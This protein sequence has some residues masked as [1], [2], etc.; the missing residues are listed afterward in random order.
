MKK[1]VATCFFVLIAYLLSAQYQNEIYNGGFEQDGFGNLLNSSNCLNPTID[2]CTGTASGFCPVADNAGTIF[3]SCGNDFAKQEEYWSHIY[4]WTCPWRR[5]FCNFGDNGVGS[6]NVVCR[7]DSRSGLKLEWG[8]K[9]EFTCA[10]LRSQMVS[11]NIYYV[12]LYNNATNSHI[13]RGMRF[14]TSRPRQCNENDIKDDGPVHVRALSTDGTWKKTTKYYQA[15]NNYS[16]IALNAFNGANEGAGLFDD[17]RIFNLGTDYCAD[18]DWHFQNT[19]LYSNIFQAANEI[20]AGNE[21]M[22][23]HYAYPGPVTIKANNNVIF[24]AGT[25]VVMDAGFSTEDG[26]YFETVIE[27]CSGSTQPPCRFTT[28]TALTFEACDGIPIEI[29]FGSGETGLQ[30]SW[31]PSTYISNTNTPNPTF[32]PPTGN[33]SITYDVTITAMCGGF[34]AS[35]FG[36]LQPSVVVSVTVI[37]TDTPIAPSLSILNE[38]YDPY[39]VSFDAL[40]G[41]TCEWISV[42]IPSS[43]YFQTFVA[44]VHFSCCTLNFSQIFDDCHLHSICQDE[45]I[46]ISVKNVCYPTPLT[47]TLLWEKPNAPVSVGPLPNVITPNGDG[48]NDQLCFDVVNAASYEL[49]LFHTYGTPINILEENEDCISSTHPCFTLDNVVDATYYFILKFF[50]CDGNLASDQIGFFAVSSLKSTSEES[51]EKPNNETSGLGPNVSIYPNPTSG[52]FTITSESV[53]SHLEVVDAQG[54]RILFKSIHQ[55]QTDVDLSDHPSGVYLVKV[56]EIDGSFT[57]HRLVME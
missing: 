52:L 21:V 13:D 44:G 24:K 17:L 55:V 12:E 43:G 9:N 2:L 25:R 15:N 23:Y 49:Y 36:V 6:A 1:I 20:T 41:L 18:D 28:P 54:K 57:L 32:T 48:I 14:Y 33:G 35:P 45:T 3:P 37:Y 7:T 22:S 31:S 4:G 46:I 40:V 39:A 30:Y 10:P 29:G 42:S 53:G 8:S 27:P 16:W 50:D 26:A 56:Y 51:I 11:G 19:D 34:P 5:G 38:V 47:Q